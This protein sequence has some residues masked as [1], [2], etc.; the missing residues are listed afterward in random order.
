VC[1]WLALEHTG[2]GTKRAPAACGTPASRRSSGWAPPHGSCDLRSG[3]CR[4]Q[5]P[6]GRGGWLA[7]ARIH[8][9]RYTQHD[10]S[11]ASL[12]AANR[13]TPAPTQHAHL[14]CVVE[15]GRRGAA[16]PAGHDHLLQGLALQGRA[17]NLLVHV[18][19]VRAVVLACAH[20]C[21]VNGGGVWCV[22]CRSGEG[23]TTMR[24]LITRLGALIWRAGT[25]RHSITP[26]GLHSRRT[27]GQQPS[28]Q[29]I[30]TL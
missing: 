4:S 7:G 19:N 25:T 14:R 17:H 16:V 15:H 20:A 2:P 30:G 9:T 6:G 3:V 8:T 18:V 1:G 29:A 26:P 21:V 23:R 12:P 28:P 22:V 10:I 24:G 5:L 13:P 27:L 11:H